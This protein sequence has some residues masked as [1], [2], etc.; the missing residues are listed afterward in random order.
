MWEGYL[1]T[2]GFMSN[3]QDHRL[4]SVRIK[5]FHR[6]FRLNIQSKPFGHKAVFDKQCDKSSNNENHKY[7]SKNIINNCIYSLTTD[8]PIPSI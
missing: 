5:I 7:N 8:T 4:I 1:K 3:M 6:N 2:D